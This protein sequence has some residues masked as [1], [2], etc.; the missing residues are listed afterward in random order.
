MLEMIPFLLPVV[1]AYGCYR[2]GR[3]ICGIVLAT[4]AYA[5]LIFSRN[6]PLI[7]SFGWRS[8]STA[9][10]AL[11]LAGVATLLVS[12]KR[13]GMGDLRQQQVM[14][15]MCAAALCSLVQ[16]PFAAPIYFCYAS[17]LVIMLAAA[18]F[19][20]TD[21]PP[22][23]VLGT[24]IAF[25]LLFAV[26]RVTPGF[27]NHMGF[28]YLPDAQTERLTIPIAGGLRVEASDAQLYDVLVSLVQ[29][30]AAGKFIYAAPDCPEVYFLSGL[31]SPRRQ[32]FDFAEETANRKDRILNSLDNLG[33][34]LVAINLSPRFSAPM[35]AELRTALDQR[36]PQRE[37]IGH[38]EVRWKK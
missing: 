17:P 15:I 38:F 28:Q 9:I 1:V 25:Y 5:V 32:Y 31:Q 33:I 11:V 8:L 27:I 10:P 14:L 3:A 34:N 21:H 13:G 30:H 16:F 19:S 24:L 6:S 12:G 7:Y 4:F 36:F 26:L 35:D 20:S 18:L 23:F 2:R 22:R 37:E 29:S